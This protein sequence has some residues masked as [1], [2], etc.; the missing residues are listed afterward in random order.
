MQ[1]KIKEIVTPNIVDA[2][3][4]IFPMDL[5]KNAAITLQRVETIMQLNY[6]L[7][8]YLVSQFIQLTDRN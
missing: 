4:K 7:R 3:T 2:L 6:I 5:P 1:E 8:P